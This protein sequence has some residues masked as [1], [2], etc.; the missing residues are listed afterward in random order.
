M[1]LQYPFEHRGVREVVVFGVPLEFESLEGSTLHRRGG[2]GVS[3]PTTVSS[4]STQDSERRNSTSFTPGLYQT[5]KQGSFRLQFCTRGYNVH[6]TLSS[7][8]RPREYIP[9]HDRNVLTHSRMRYSSVLSTNGSVRDPCP[10][11]GKS[12]DL[13]SRWSSNMGIGFL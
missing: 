5:Y 11:G 9:N 12:G 10:G 3:D 2:G 6:S 8:N 4:S 13:L 1:G 7:T